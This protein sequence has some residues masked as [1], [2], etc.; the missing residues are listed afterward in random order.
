MDEI[1]NCCITC[2]TA[3]P[4]S[5]CECRCGGRFHATYLRKIQG[6]KY[7][8]I[9]KF[10]GGE[11][12]GFIEQCENHTL[13]CTCGHDIKMNRF[14]G[15]EHSAGLK[16]ENGIQWWIFVICAKCGYEWNFQKMQKRLH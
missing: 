6:K 15:Y 4:T 1:K 13:G 9:N 7:R 2:Q 3:K 5:P 14:L 12:Q 8:T 11:I 10:L 16:D